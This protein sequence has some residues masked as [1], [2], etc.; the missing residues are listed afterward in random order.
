M[1]LRLAQDEQA[2]ALLTADRNQEYLRSRM[3]DDERAATPPVDFRPFIIAD[4]DTGES[5][6][7]SSDPHGR[8]GA[9]RSTPP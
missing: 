9:W 6:G 5:L 2:D 8:I 1:N 3:S 4:A 7:C